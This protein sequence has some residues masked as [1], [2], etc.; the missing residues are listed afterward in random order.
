MTDLPCE[1]VLFDCDGV[2]VDSNAAVEDAW[3]RWARDLGLEPDA[4]LARIHGQRS[5]DT[6]REFVPLEQQPAELDRID[7]YELE[8]AHEV[9]AIPG[10]G[11]LVASMP[12]GRWAVVTSGITAL[13]T[14]RLR[15]AGIRA[16]DVL[17]CADDVQRG[18][19]DPE[20]YAL[21]ARRLGVAPQRTI[22]LED[23]PAGIAAARA[24]GVGAVVGIGERARDAAVDGWAP[25][26]RA[27]HW[28]GDA[29]RVW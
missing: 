11:A 28:T 21:A 26:L 4:V 24:A 6:V 29:I 7:R 23:A 10:A 8:T 1:A 27:V 20:G 25:D 18:K 5:Q 9:R 19:P 16:P 17:V 14:A 3:V 12:P 22:V 15:G 2:L 13:A